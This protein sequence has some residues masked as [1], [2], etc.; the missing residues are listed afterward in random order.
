MA[1]FALLIGVSEYQSNLLNPL[2][3]VLKDIEIMQRVLQ[4]P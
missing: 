1:K 3:G 2:P 4:H